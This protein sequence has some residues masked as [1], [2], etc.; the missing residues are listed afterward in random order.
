MTAR[1][2]KD[3]AKDQPGAAAAKK[4]EASRTGRPP[5]SRAF[6]LEELQRVID[7]FIASDL[8]ELEVEEAGRRVR[9]VSPRAVPAPAPPGA[10]APPPT[11]PTHEKPATPHAAEKPAS[12][13][14][15]EGLVTIDAP[16]VGTFYTTPAPGEPPFVL[17]GDQVDAGQT[18]CIVEAMKIMNE[19]PAKVP[20]IIERILVENGEA[21]EYGQPLFAVRP[22]A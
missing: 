14:D 16:M 11:P 19:V 3:T 5:A 6:D 4:R 17:P 15:M 7:L 13:L 22:I 20:A 12:T 21:V 10:L 9:L 18:V 8:A 2:K 1:E